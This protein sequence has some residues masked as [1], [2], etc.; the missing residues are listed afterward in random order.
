MG[1]PGVYPPG[2]APP[3]FP[4]P[5]PAITINS[6]GEPTYSSAN[7]DPEPTK[8]S[9]SS[10]S[11]SSASTTSSSSCKITE[12]AS[13]CVIMTSYRVNTADHT[14]ET[15]TSSSCTPVSGCT[16]TGTTQTSLTTSTTTAACYRFPDA[17][18]SESKRNLR[19]GDTGFF[20]FSLEPRG[21]ARQ[22]GRDALGSCKLINNNK[23]F[24]PEH[25]GPSEIVVWMKNRNTPLKGAYIVPEQNCGVGPKVTLLS[26][27]EALTSQVYYDQERSKYAAMGLTDSPFIQTEH[28]CK[29]YRS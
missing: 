26:D 10:S 11:R 24:V 4:S 3:G 6:I 22:K 28:V 18:S 20:G 2:P 19:E 25:K 16:A 7:S 9:T 15:F 14:T 5:L 29:L 17:T 8:E 1:F 27:F 23:L 21:K 13:S 12:T